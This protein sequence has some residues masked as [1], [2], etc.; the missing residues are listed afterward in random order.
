MMLVIQQVG[1]NVRLRGRG[2]ELVCSSVA[3]AR[4]MLQLWRRVYAPECSTVSGF[5][6]TALQSLPG[7]RGQPGRTQKPRV[8]SA[9]H[10]AAQEK[11]G[12]NGVGAVNPVFSGTVPENSN[13]EATDA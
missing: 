2:G 10:G 13:A 6:V 9:P 3:Q 12:K 1:D 4:F 5:C 7:G 11:R 8:F